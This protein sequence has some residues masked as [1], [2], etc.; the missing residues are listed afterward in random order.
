[1][2]TN[3][4]LESL[5]IGQLLVESKQA[6]LQFYG[7]TYCKDG[8]GK[9]RHHGV[10]NGFDYAALKLL[11]RPRREFAMTMKHSQ[12]CGVPIA[13]EVFR[14]AYYVGEEDGYKRLVLTQLFVNLGARL[15]EPINSA[16]L[17]F[18]SE[19]PAHHNAIS[20]RY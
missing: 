15:E 1:M 17:L 10:T 2:D 3:P 7:T 8:I 4:E 18:H 13:I 9:L 16:L 19:A 20:T 5:A 11:R 12:P 14:G 6:A